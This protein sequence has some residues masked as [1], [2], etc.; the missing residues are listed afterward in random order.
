MSRA[1]GPLPPSPADDV[2]ALGSL[3]L[4]VLAQ[5][6]RPELRAALSAA[7]DPDPRLRPAASELVRE[8]V[9]AAPP[10][11][12]R[13]VADPLDEP[14]RPP[15]HGRRPGS[16]PRPSRHAGAPLRTAVSGMVARLGLPVLGAATAVLLAA[17]AGSAWARLSRPTSAGPSRRAVVDPRP[18]ATGTDW[19]AVLARLDAVRAQAFSGGDPLAMTAADAAGSP[20]FASDLA[21]ARALASAGVHASGYRTTLISVRLLRASP[22]RVLL[23]VSDRRSAYLLVRADGTVVARRPGRPPATWQVELVRGA[24]GWLVSAV[25]RGCADQHAPADPCSPTSPPG[26]AA[27]RGP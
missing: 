9:A 17:L 14:V 6:A 26:P 25:T 7:A 22:V 12:V 20:A 21:A 2:A 3:L 24:H 27:P 8:V 16:L 15:T 18:T 19:Q 23:R 1:A 11:P 4:G 5:P 13:L 10:E